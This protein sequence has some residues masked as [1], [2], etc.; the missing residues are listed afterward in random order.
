MSRAK[1]TNGIFSIILV[2]I[3]FTFD[4]SGQDTH[5]TQFSNIPLYFNPAYTGVYTGARVRFN[6]RIQNT[7]T[8]RFNGYHL[9][10]DFGDRNLPG[11][12][13]FGVMVNTDD[14]GV[15]FIRNFDLG[16]SFAARVPF[17]R[18]LIGQVGIKATWNQKIVSWDDFIL[19]D[20]LTEAYGHLYDSCAGRHGKSSLNAADFGI[21]GL[22][23]F[24]GQGGSFSGTAGVAVDHLFEPDQSL[25]ETVKAPLARKYTVHADFVFSV[26]CPTGLNARE[27]DPLKINPGIVIQHQGNVNNYQVGLNLTNYGLYFGVWC[28]GTYGPVKSN[29]ISLLGGYRYKVSETTSVKCTYSYDMQVYGPH[30]CDGGIHEISLVIE[31]GSLHIFRGSGNAYRNFSRKNSSNDGKNQ[32]AYASF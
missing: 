6:S 9:S 4:S 32:L 28:N 20:K 1:F 16:T 8:S 17:T 2:T 11:S 13:G 24:V 27:D 22:V 23:Q 26:K 29:S 30:K 18:Y 19:S 31:F 7:T 15:R 10:A 3:L 25:I 5:Y 12:G 14:Q 21:G